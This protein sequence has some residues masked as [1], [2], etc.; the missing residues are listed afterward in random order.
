MEMKFAIILTLD[1]SDYQP[2]SDISSGFMLLTSKAILSNGAVSL[3]VIYYYY[4][5]TISKY[6][7]YR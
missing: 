2:I 4:L 1:W 6:I 5:I 7:Y 3:I